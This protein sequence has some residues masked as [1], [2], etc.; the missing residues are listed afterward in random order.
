MNL[1]VNFKSQQQINEQLSK[2]LANEQEVRLKIE[3]ELRKV[4]KDLK[5][6]EK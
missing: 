1:S 6:T 3:V 2:T 5:K 4:E